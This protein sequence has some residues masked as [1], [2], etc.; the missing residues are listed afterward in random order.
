M[1]S[2]YSEGGVG[3]CLC[4]NTAYGIIHLKMQRVDICMKDKNRGFTIVELLIVIVV[5]GILAAIVMV[6]YNGVT[7][8]AKTAGIKSDISGFMKKIEQVKVLSGDGLY[9][10]IAGMS[11]QHF[12][13]TKSF[14][15]QGRNNWYYCPSADRTAYAI[16]VAVLLC[17]L[18]MPAT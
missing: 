7:N 15:T 16:G 4:T 1:A 3:T 5:I 9:P 10:T 13:V 6:A 17:C 8:S 12:K 14:Y 18:R 2:F 11:N